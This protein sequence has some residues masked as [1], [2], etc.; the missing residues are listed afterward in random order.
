MHKKI[1]KLPKDFKGLLWGYNFNLIDR[2]EDKRII[3]VNTIN[4]GNL[5][6]WK[7]LVQ[8]Y[9]KERLRKIIKSIPESEF[10]KPALKLMKLL[11]RIKKLKYASRSAQIRA[12]KGI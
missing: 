9:G 4:Y 2:E 5:N 3:I 10:R 1:K 12:E 7:W 8:T 6:Q 11:F